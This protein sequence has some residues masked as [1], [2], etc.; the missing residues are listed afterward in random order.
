MGWIEFI[1]RKGF[2][3]LLGMGIAGVAVIAV[4]I[5]IIFMLTRG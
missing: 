5:L 1:M 4:L 2:K 3:F